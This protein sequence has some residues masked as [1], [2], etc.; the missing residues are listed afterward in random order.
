MKRLYTGR[1]H[2]GDVTFEVMADIAAG[3]HKCNCSICAASRFWS[4]DALPSD[5][6][7]LSP[8]DMMTVFRGRNPVAEHPFCKRCGI[9]PFQRIGMPNMSGHEYLNVNIACL[10]AVDVDELM[11]APITFYDGLHDKWGE[12]PQEVRH[13]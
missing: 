1:C 8:P 13:L 4:V 12:R 7:L 6:R 11:A 2:C 3:T 9:R 10:E 5:L